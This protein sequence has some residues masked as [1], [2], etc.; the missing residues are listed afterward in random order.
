MISE[1]QTIENPVISREEAI[2]I[3]NTPDEIESA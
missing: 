3:L 2:E 1:L